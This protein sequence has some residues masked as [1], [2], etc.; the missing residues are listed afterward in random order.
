MAPHS[1]IRTGCVLVAM[2]ASGC[3]S[4]SSYPLTWPALPETAQRACEQVVG[5]YKDQGQMYG[6]LYS[7]ARSLTEVVIGQNDRAWRAE[8]VTL[9]FPRE[10]QFQIGVSGPEGQSSSAT[11]TADEGRFVCQTGTVMLRRPAQWRGGG[12]GPAIGLGRLSVAL[13]LFLVEDYL[14]VKREEHVF[15]LLG[16]MV[17]VV[18]RETDWYRFERTT[19]APEGTTES[20]RGVHWRS[21]PP[22]RRLHP[23]TAEPL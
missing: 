6:T 9:S 21:G 11:F 16:F 12:A 10:G 14:V 19:R 2:A 23:T 5:T 13:E 4:R 3:S 7:P 15:M 17:P 18:D 8:S 1:V 22:N 20:I